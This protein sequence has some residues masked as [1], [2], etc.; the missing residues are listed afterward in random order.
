MSGPS[1]GQLYYVWT[2]VKGEGKVK[3]RG[4]AVTKQDWS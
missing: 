3:A 4:V 1:L 2:M